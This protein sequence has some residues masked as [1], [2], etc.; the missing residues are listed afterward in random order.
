MLKTNPQGRFL[1]YYEIILKAGK[2]KQLNK[3]AL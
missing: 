2:E 3:Q 1:S